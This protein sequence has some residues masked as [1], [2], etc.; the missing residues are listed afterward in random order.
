MTEW[1]IRFPFREPDSP[2]TDV[3]IDAQD[4]EDPEERAVVRALV[5][6][7]VLGGCAT[8]GDLRVLLASRTPAERRPL[9]DSAREAAG[10][11]SASDIE[12]DEKFE[13]VQQ[14]ARLNSS[15]RDAEGKAFQGC[16][17]QDCSAFPMDAAGLP[18]PVADRRWWCDRHRHLAEPGD[19]EPPVDVV[20]IDGLFGLVEAPS[21][22]AAMQAKDDRRREADERRRREHRA[23]VEA[24]R[25]A[26]ERYYEEHKNDPDVNPWA[27]AGWAG[28]T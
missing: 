16:A 19:D 17:A 6:Q 18:V 27:G 22:V 4:L 21:V 7:A 12:A 28:R 11:K 26:E 14:Q 23:E 9:L 13:A 1:A 5:L 2:I 15:G 24:I 20:A 10:L 8:A 25:K 3:A